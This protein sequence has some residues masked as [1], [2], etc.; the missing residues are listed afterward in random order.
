MFP[1]DSRYILQSTC[2]FTCRFKGNFCA[3]SNVS[4]RK[5]LKGQICYAPQC[6]LFQFWKNSVRKRKEGK[7]CTTSISEVF[8]EGM[9]LERSPGHFDPRSS[10]RQGV[11]ER[12]DF[13]VCVFNLFIRRAERSL[14]AQGH[15]KMISLFPVRDIFL[16]FISLYLIFSAPIS[17]IYLSITIYHIPNFRPPKILFGELCVKKINFWSY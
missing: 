10:L 9:H 13:C 2:V 1:N 7:T 6:F 11:F 5:L 14:F 15:V 17:W 8:F 3:R 12:F 16:R 4:G